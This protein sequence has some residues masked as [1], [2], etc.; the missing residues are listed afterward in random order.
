MFPIDQADQSA[1]ALFSGIQCFDLYRIVNP[2][3]FETYEYRNRTLIVQPDCCYALWK[4]TAPCHNCSS[5]RAAATHDHVMKLEHLDDQIILVVSIPIELCGNELILELAKNV[6]TSLIINDIYHN[7]YRD[8][9]A[10][11]CEFNDLAVRDSFTGLYN[12]RFIEQELEQNVNHAISSH[13]P[14]TAAIVD[15]DH[16]KLVNDTYGHN[17]GDTVILTIVS[18]FQKMI[19]EKSAW[20]GRL[21]G[22]EFLLVFPGCSY[23]QVAPLCQSIVEKV[24]AHMYQKN[25]KVF[26]V[27][28]SIGIKEFSFCEDHDSI[29][30]L[31]HVDQEMYHVKRKKD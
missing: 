5:R 4:R 26:F 9:F 22:D 12:K 20:I 7:N 29:T 28:I 18:Y 11:I 8:I 19:H 6:T 21:G 10:M 23:E 30:F 31:D 16:F 3:T 24:S 14:L 15:I 17:T 27:S 25:D 1:L 2:L 13:T